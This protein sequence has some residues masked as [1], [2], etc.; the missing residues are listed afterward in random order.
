VSGP[1]LGT[2]NTHDHAGRVTLFA[3]AVGYTEAI[4]ANVREKVAARLS[5]V[6]A[7]L[8]GYRVRVC[9]RQRDLV[10]VCRRSVWRI[11]R[12]RYVPVHG[13]RAGV[14]PHRGT[15][16]IEAVRVATGA[17]EV[18]LLPH[19]IN[20]AFAPYVRGERWFR[21]ARWGW[22]QAVDEALIADY[23]ARGFEVHALGDVNTP[24]DVLGFPGLPWE[25]GRGFDRVASTIDLDDVTYLGHA[26]SDHPRL[27]AQLAR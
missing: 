2:H 10:F 12:T 18:F 15:F 27:R 9:R 16:V 14:T 23:R 17:R 26:G 20:A 22:H 4:G 11:T 8:G 21:S 5:R 19:R 3:D 1:T 6:R 25:V 24:D 13:G 7:R